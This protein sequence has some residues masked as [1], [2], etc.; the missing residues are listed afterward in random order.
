MGEWLYFGFESVRSNNT[1]TLHPNIFNNTVFS[2]NDD[3]VF[4]SYDENQA[5]AV[6]AN[7]VPSV[8][9]PNEVR[10][11]ITREPGSRV[12]T[13]FKDYR[14]DGDSA[15]PT[16]NKDDTVHFISTN[17]RLKGTRKSCLL[18]KSSRL[19]DVVIDASNW[20]AS[21]E[22][23]RRLFELLEAHDES[24]EL[25]PAY[26]LVDDRSDEYE[27]EYEYRPSKS[28]VIR[29]S[30]R[31]PDDL[32]VRWLKPRLTGYGI[33]APP[34]IDPISSSS[35]YT[36]HESADYYFVIETEFEIVDH[37]NRVLEQRGDTRQL[38]LGRDSKTELGPLDH[39]PKEMRQAL[40]EDDWQIQ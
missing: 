3:L 40:D 16:F 11:D 25:F 20:D 22:N 26:L 30:R 4:W 7:R 17:D 10:T 8:L 32:R 9:N 18:V 39:L 6:I 15:Y 27:L 5:S 33:G 35:Y 36:Q 13:I 34:E 1:I 19:E 14:Q 28:G 24:A 2:S 37:E 31:V 23:I 21:D 38:H 29:V 12:T